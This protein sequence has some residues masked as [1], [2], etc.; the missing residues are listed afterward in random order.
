MN[1]SIRRACWKLIVDSTALTG[2]N[3]PP[4]LSLKQATLEMLAIAPPLSAH[5]MHC[6]SDLNE[7][8]LT[9]RRKD[10]S[11]AVDR[12]RRLWR[13]AMQS[14]FANNFPYIL[15]GHLDDSNYACQEQAIGPR[16]LFGRRLAEAVRQGENGEYEGKG[17]FRGHLRTPDAPRT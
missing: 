13:T 10:R 8:V 12:S 7:K 2:I 4:T 1:Q 14:A 6:A 3:A 17:L 16:G 11:S 15:V 9:V 5:V